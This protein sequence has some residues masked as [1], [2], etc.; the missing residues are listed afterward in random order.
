LGVMF[1]I[2]K[3]A[4]DIST[5]LL[6][7]ILLSPLFIFLIFAVKVS[8][9]GSVFF[10]QSRIGRHKNLFVMLKFRT[11]RTDAPKDIPTHLLADPDAYITPLGK[12]MRRTSLDEIP[13]IFNILK[14]DMSVVGPRPALWNQ[15]DLVAFRDQYGANDVRPGL[16]G[17]AQISG[18]DELPIA[19]K[20]AYDGEY[21]EKMSFLFDC[22]IIWR[23]VFKVAKS[24]GVKEG[25]KEEKAVEESVA[26]KN[27]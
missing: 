3:R 9:P 26:G 6:A 19:V 13:Q 15:D 8:S 4:F 1:L 20:A 24:E 21:V 18:R 12:F 25:V 27:G 17:L 16:T 22:R 2:F 23:T 14:G 5:S 11:M 10:K 7:I